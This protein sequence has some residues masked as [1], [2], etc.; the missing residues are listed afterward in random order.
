[1]AP[2]EGTV[3]LPEAEEHEDGG[4]WTPT[5]VFDQTIREI[6]DTTLADAH[7]PSKEFR[8]Q[9]A[10]GAEDLGDGFLLHPEPALVKRGPDGGIVSVTPLSE[11]P[12]VHYEQGKGLVKDD[13]PPVEGR[14]RP[15]PVPLPTAQREKLREILAT[16]LFKNYAQEGSLRNLAHYNP[17][18][19]GIPELPAGS[20]QHLQPRPGTK[21][22]RASEGQVYQYLLKVVAERAQIV[23]TK[24]YGGG[25]LAD[26]ALRI[27]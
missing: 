25:T 20:P 14:S 27:E 17:L 22:Y 24:K 19:D 16:R 3:I 13:A 12:G 10:E 8:K 5:V 9:L 15:T 21:L 18:R 1:M 2:D 23:D 26:M 11:L 6:T 7:A 4:G